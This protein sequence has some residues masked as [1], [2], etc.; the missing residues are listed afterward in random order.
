MQDVLD[1]EWGDRLIRAW[2]EGWW[3]APARIGERLAPLLGAGSGPG[4]HQR[5][6]LAQPV[7]AGRQRSDLR[8]DR[9]R[10]VTDTLNFPSDLYILQGVAELLGGGHQI[11]RIDSHDGGITP[12]L[13]ALMDAIDEQTRRW[14]HFRT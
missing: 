8:P 9:K 10:I 13:V 4:D 5:S 11:I 2:N 1:T 14:W 6:D 7:Q 12:D 3:E